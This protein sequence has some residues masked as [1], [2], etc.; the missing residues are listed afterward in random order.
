[1]S[2]SASGQQFATLVSGLSNVPTRVNIVD[3][4]V[5]YLV[6]HRGRW[7]P[8]W[9]LADL[10]YGGACNRRSVSV[11]ISRARRRGLRVE[12]SAFGYRIGRPGQQEGDCPVC[13][14]PRVRYEG[15]WVCYGC[16]GTSVVDLEVGRAMPVGEHSGKGWDEEQRRRL[17]ELW[18]L[19]LTQEAIG[20]ELGRSASAVRAEAASLGLGRKRYV[21][22]R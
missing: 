8:G 18:P 6:G 11:V 19:D 2:Q 14:A 12:S 7:V 4:A 1:M 10:L 15:E 5:Q 17:R 13:S 3:V 16:P 21:R 22:G 9:E 20:E